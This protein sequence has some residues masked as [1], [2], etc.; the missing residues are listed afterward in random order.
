MH[1]TD[2][3]L[4]QLAMTTVGKVLEKKGFEFLAIESGLKK[5]PQFVCHINKQLAFVL[6]KHVCYPDDPETYDTIW[7]EAMKLHA[8][9]KSAELYFCGVGFGNDDDLSLSPKKSSNLLVKFSGKIQ[10]IE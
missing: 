10:K 3:E 8:K 7:M 1:Y 5:N 2:Q 6:V 4:H 9:S